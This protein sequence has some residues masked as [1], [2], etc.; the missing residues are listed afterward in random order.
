MRQVLQPAVLKINMN[1]PAAA[2]FLG[3]NKDGSLTLSLTSAGI[4]YKFARIT[5]EAWRSIE[6]SSSDDRSYG[7]TRL[8]GRRKFPLDGGRQGAHTSRGKHT[9]QS[10]TPLT[11]DWT[12]LLAIS[13]L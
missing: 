5:P 12:P 13:R 11:Q 2:G 4:D 1:T 3:L 10:L 9:R 8:Y 7:L 6:T